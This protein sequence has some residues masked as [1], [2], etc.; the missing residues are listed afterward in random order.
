[1]FRRTSWLSSNFYRIVELLW[2]KIGQICAINIAVGPNKNIIRARPKS[3]ETFLILNRSVGEDTLANP[4][5]KNFRN[6]FWIGKEHERQKQPLTNY[7]LLIEVKTKEC[8]RQS[9]ESLFWKDLNLPTFIESLMLFIGPSA[10]D[11]TL[12][13]RSSLAFLQAPHLQRRRFLFLSGVKLIRILISRR[14]RLVVLFWT[15]NL[16]LN[17]TQIRS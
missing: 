2:N 15:G 10:R 9:E 5:S 8:G 3:E 17:S 16:H 6:D 11:F 13:L 7:R 4:G 12:L 14:L 1:M